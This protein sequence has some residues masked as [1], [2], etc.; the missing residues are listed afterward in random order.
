MRSTQ[1]QLAR[2]RRSAA[3]VRTRL[4]AQAMHWQK[5]RKV[6][7]HEPV[8]RHA[9]HVRRLHLIADARLA[10]LLGPVA[11]SHHSPEHWGEAADLIESELRAAGY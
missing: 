10:R 5:Q 8:A 1:R 11:E 9:A 7:K 2:R 3:S 6:S 4:D